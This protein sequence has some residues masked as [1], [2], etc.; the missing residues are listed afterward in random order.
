[1]LNNDDSKLE[2]SK[3]AF[4]SAF[5]NLHTALKTD[6]MIPSKYRNTN[7][8]S[9]ILNLILQGQAVSRNQELNQV[10]I[11]IVDQI[12]GNL[13]P[14]I[15]DMIPISSGLD[16]VPSRQAPVYESGDEMTDPGLKR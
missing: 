8:L 9:E 13:E 2:E 15:I 7:D 5:E 11:N 3:A 10:G 1:M 16:N 4:Q 12:S 6:G 14:H